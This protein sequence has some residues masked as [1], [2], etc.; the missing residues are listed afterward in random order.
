MTDGVSDGALYRL[1]SGV[2]N[3]TALPSTRLCG[4]GK[5]GSIPAVRIAAISSQSSMS[6]SP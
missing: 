6:I 4:I 3:R 5:V 2:D 1:A